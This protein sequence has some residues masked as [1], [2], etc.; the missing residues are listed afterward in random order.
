MNGYKK[1]LL[2]TLMALPFAA[3][4]AGDAAAQSADCSA[5]VQRVLAQT[6]GQL[7]SVKVAKN[8]GQPVCKITVLAPDASGKRRRKMTVNARP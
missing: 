5:A 1:I 4:E 3:L 7:L 6:N 8:G 2:V